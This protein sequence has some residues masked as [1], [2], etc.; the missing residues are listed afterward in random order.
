MGSRQQDRFSNTVQE[1]TPHTASPPKID[2]FKTSILVLVLII[3][4]S[5]GGQMMVATPP[6]WWGQEEAQKIE[7]ARTKSDFVCHWAAAQLVAEKR[8]EA[9]YE[10]QAV[11][12]LMVSQIQPSP[13]PPPLPLS[14]QRPPDK[15]EAGEWGLAYPPTHN[16]LLAPLG[17]MPLSLAFQL[18][19]LAGLLLYTGMVLLWRAGVTYTLAAIGSPWVIPCVLGG[20]NGLLTAAFLGSGFALLARFPILAGISFGL[21]CFKPQ[22]AFLVPMLLVIGGHTRAFL[23]AAFTVA[24]MVG[25]SLLAFGEEPWLAFFARSTDIV[26]DILMRDFLWGRMYSV[27]AMMLHAGAPWLAAF[28][29]QTISALLAMFIAGRVWKQTPHAGLRAASAIFATY[30]CLPLVYDYDF[31]A[32]TIGLLGILLYETQNKWKFFAL[33]LITLLYIT[34]PVFHPYGITAP[35]YVYIPLCLWGLLIITS[36]L[37]HEKKPSRMEEGSLP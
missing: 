29:T 26:G 14:T 36:L 28:I 10:S 13:T 22:F 34:P 2:L 16:L 23:A 32:V 24:G 3:F 8:P 9:V 12:S 11:R 15:K 19:T 7:L 37:A 18:Y 35:Y 25:A 27:T 20:Q 6:S 17:G 1:P 5:W 31:P 21:C 4:L 30:L 33:P